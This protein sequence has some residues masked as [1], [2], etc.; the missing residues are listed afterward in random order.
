MSKKSN[1]AYQELQKIGMEIIKNAI[2][3]ENDINTRSGKRKNVNFKNPKDLKKFYEYFE[4]ERY[5]DIEPLSNKIIEKFQTIRENFYKDQSDHN[6]KIKSLFIAIQRSFI[7][8]KKCDIKRYQELDIKK[9]HDFY[10]KLNN[11]LDSLEK[12]IDLT[13]SK[14]VQEVISKAT[15]RK[16]EHIALYYFKQYIFGYEVGKKIKSH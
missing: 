6:L 2:I 13:N 9:L 5:Q 7:N 1:Q 4:L 16:L 14:I 12:K 11:Y 15:K 8:E 10:F 3:D